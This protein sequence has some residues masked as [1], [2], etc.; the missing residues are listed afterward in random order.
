MNVTTLHRAAGSEKP[1]RTFGLLLQAV[2][3]AAAL[4]AAK[5][6]L[7]SEYSAWE[8]WGG[9]RGGTRTS[10][11]DQITPANVGTLVGAWQFHTGDLGNRAP[12]LMA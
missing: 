1:R 11:L 5:P 2:L 7:A 6:A 9:D 12:E 3:L 10:P 8:Y 4:F